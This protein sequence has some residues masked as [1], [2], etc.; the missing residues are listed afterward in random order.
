[1]WPHC[2]PARTSKPASFRPV[3]F[4]PVSFK[5]V[6]FRP[7]L[8]APALLALTALAGCQS[9]ARQDP[10][11]T[12]ASTC[13]YMLPTISGART[14]APGK[15][16]AENQKGIPDSLIAYADPESPAFCDRPLSD[17]LPASIEMADYVHG[18]NTTGLFATLQQSGPFTVFGIPNTV[19]EQYAKRTNGKLT[20][21]ENTA[22]LREILAY[23]IVKGKWS[24]D[25]LRAAA[26]AS[27]T[28]SVGLPTLNG[29]TLSA[30]IDQ[31][32]GQIILGNGEGMTTR[33]WVT[34]VPQS[35]GMLYFT[36]SLLLPPVSQP[37]SAPRHARAATRTTARKVTHTAMASQAAAAPVA[38]FTSQPLPGH[39]AASA[40]TLATPPG[41]QDDLV[42]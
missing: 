35:N 2:A 20:T 24:A 41:L 33:L 11:L 8:L 38:A 23:S 1:M 37:A 3:S 10:Y 19:L 12:H 14:Y 26:L 39:R 22:L 30:W 18:L 34:G 32:T 40:N 42:R 7:V 27:P 29:R 31:P 6:S 9:Q 5:R 36:Q 21:P 25:K 28:H 4:K 16:A 13:S 15:A 17:T